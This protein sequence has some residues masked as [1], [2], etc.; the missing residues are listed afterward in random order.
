VDVWRCVVLHW[1]VDRHSVLRLP[2]EHDEQ[3]ALVVLMGYRYPNH[4]H[5]LFAVPNG[6]ARNKI[7]AALLK[8]E[9]VTPGVPDLFLAFPTA[10]CAGLFLEMKRRGATA[11][12][13][14]PEQ[15]TKLIEFTA[16]GYACA[17]AAGADAGLAVI[18]RYL[19][20][21]TWQ[22]EWYLPETWAR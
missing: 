6:G 12:K 4:A 3:A 1:A 14:T 21:D 2:T 8:A 18:D 11:S 7:P 16:A 20:A 9:G 19:S 5:L 15:R 13:V 17:W 10:G 22:P